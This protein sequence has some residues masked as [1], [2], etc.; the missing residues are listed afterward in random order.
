MA[1][2]PLLYDARTPHLTTWLSQDH[3]AGRQTLGCGRAR[4]PG[5]LTGQVGVVEGMGI[6]FRLSLP[7]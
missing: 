3:G 1:S 7:A 2:L 6:G 5:D 4:P